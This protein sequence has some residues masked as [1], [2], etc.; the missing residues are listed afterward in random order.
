MEE[1]KNNVALIAI[2][3]G[4]ICLAGGLVC[5]FF[6]GKN[7]T[8]K[9]ETNNLVNK[10]LDLIDKVID[11]ASEELDKHSQINDYTCKN[12]NCER[13]EVSNI[14]GLEFY[15]DG[16]TLIM[17][18]TSSK[19][20]KEYDLTDYLIYDDDTEF[21]VSQLNNC[22][23]VGYYVELDVPAFAIMPDYTTRSIT[24]KTDWKR[25][26]T[27]DIKIRE[28]SPSAVNKANEICK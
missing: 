14:T 19:T 5:G 4:V 26:M 12:T 24:T 18:N 20:I 1:K 8:V 17:F 11:K 10:G 28:L 13:I 21:V 9:K 23:I 22:F 7:M 3:V 6:V 16:H 27:S 15:V 2:I 25:E